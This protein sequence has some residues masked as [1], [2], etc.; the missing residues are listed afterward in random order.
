MKGKTVSVTLPNKV[1]DEYDREATKMETSRG[2]ILRNI[3][4]DDYKSRMNK[5]EGKLDPTNISQTN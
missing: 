2:S 5:M 1:V 3:I 4:M